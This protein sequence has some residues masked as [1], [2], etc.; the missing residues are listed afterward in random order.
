MDG[1]FRQLAGDLCRVGQLMVGGPSA[2]RG[3][4]STG[5]EVG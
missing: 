2:R 1:L 4:A 3:L 5:R